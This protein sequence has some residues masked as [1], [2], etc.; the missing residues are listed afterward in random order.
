[1]T[2][3]PDDGPEPPRQS[4]SDRLRDRTRIAHETAETA[5]FV[6]HLLAGALP[7]G[8]YAALAAQ[9]HAIYSALESATGR[10]RGDP[11]AGPF[12][13]DELARIPSLEHDLAVLLGSGWAQAARQL[14]LP[15][16]DAYAAHVAEVAAARPVSFVAHH[17][18]R[19][20]GDLS[21]GQVIRQRLEQHYG[22]L[23]RE[24][25]S[26]YVFAAIPKLKP[27]RDRYRRLLDA[28]SLTAEEDEWLVGEAVLAF[29]F[30]HAVFT[31]LHDHC[32]ITQHA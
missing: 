12:V 7:I 22:E 3:S 21:G 14:R 19:Y 32:R 25:G 9:N 11:I 24:A 28:L 8:A 29:E 26:S 4:L 5:P 6:G 20:L 16:T 15:A 31:D 23:G 30:N 13:L 27:F 17:Y 1:M 18:V 10:W 2:A